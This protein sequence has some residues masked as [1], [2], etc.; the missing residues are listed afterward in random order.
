VR[1]KVAACLLF[2]LAP[3][4]AQ[5]SGDNT[6]PSYTAAGI[7]NTASAIAGFYA[8]DMFISIYGTNLSYVTE[9]M[10]QADL[11]AG[12]LPTALIGTG[13]RVLINQIAADIWYVSPTLVN[14]LVPA[15]LVAGPAVVQLE[16]DGIAGPPITIMLG[17]TAP[18]LFQ[19]DATDVLGTHLN[20]SIITAAAPA[21]PGEWIVLYAT[22]L[23]PTVPAAVPNQVPQS[24]ARLA[25]N[26]FSVMLN[27]A[28]I[29]PSRIAYAGVT[30][31]YA[32][33][34][35][36]NVLLP[37]DAPANPEI[38]VGS[39]TVLSVAGRYLFVQP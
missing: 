33:L 12:I 19:I 6:A 10:T 25:S 3:L 26:D 24:A 18:S 9:A 37:D 30:P 32:G 36:I 27:G 35:Q 34:F 17:S 1:S 11:A 13:V 38:Q 5:T 39:S 20:G 2:T 29:D 8:P 23:G 16:V 28:A 22:G 4:M 14:L 31:G 7:A 15:S 21:Q